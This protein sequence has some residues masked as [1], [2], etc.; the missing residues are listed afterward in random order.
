MKAYKTKA[1]FFWHNKIREPY[2]VV[3]VVEDPNG[4]W[5]A[6]KNVYGEPILGTM[7]QNCVADWDWL[8][9]HGDYTKTY[10]ESTYK[11]VP[12]GQGK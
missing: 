5:K 12:H 1:G 10:T 8:H 6:V 11:V 2:E 3:N 7:S 4:D 9:K